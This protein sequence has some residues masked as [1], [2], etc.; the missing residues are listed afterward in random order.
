MKAHAVSVR[1]E[2]TNTDLPVPPVLNFS[3]KLL[4]SAVGC[5]FPFLTK[6]N[7]E[8]ISVPPVK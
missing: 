3:E 2:K 1:R 8:P 7:N 5:V 6:W 4:N